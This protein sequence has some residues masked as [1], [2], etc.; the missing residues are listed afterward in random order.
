MAID[1]YGLSKKVRCIKEL[2]LVRATACSYSSATGSRSHKCKICL[3]R[4]K[5]PVALRRL[6]WVGADLNAVLGYMRLP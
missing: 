6:G 5:K 2:Q 1:D 3:R 4:F